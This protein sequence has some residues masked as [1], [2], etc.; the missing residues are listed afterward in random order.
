MD[1]EIIIRPFDVSDS[2]EEITRLL[3]RSYAQLAEMGLRYMATHQDDSVTLKRLVDGRS[4]LAE[5]QGDL[6]GTITC[7]DSDHTSGSPYLDR[8]NVGH[9]GQFGVAPGFQRRGIGRRLFDRAESHAHEIGLD[10]VALDTA[11]TAQHLID[12]YERLGYRLIECV[13]WEVT[14]YRSVVL[15]KKLR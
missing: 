13:S 2:V 8:P 7:Y 4:F 14:N 12:W 9:I 3:H 11:E 10:E 15:G 1:D 6:L 5:R